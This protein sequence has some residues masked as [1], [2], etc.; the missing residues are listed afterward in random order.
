MLRLILLT[1]IIIVF[2]LNHSTFA[3]EQNMPDFTISKVFTTRGGAHSTTRGTIRLVHDY[4]GKWLVF[5]G[6]PDMYHFSS[7]GV[8]WT[9]QE[10]TQFSSRSYLIR[11]DTIYSFANVDV[12]PDPEKIERVKATFK[13][14]ISGNIIEWGEPHMLPHLTVSYYEDLQQDSTG[15]FTVSGRVPQ[16]DAEGKVTSTTIEWSR[17]L[18]PN[19]ITAWEPQ[20]QVIHH[21]GDMQS[22]E[23]HENIPL[24]DGKSYL[25]GMLSVNKQ[26]RLYGNLFDGE[27]WGAEDTLLA[28]NMSTVR[29]TDKRMSAVWDSRAKVIHMTYVDHDSQLWYRVCKSPYRSENWS[30]PVKLKPFKVF[31]NVMSMD[32]SKTPAHLC[33]V[34]GKTIYEH[35]D[36]RWQSGELYL[37]KYD[38]ESWSESTLISEPGTKY[39][40]YPNMNED[41][42]KGIG[43]V[44]L[45][46]VPEN[47]RAV[48]NTDHDIMFVS[49][50]AP[51]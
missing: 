51:K 23:V 47:Q 34:Y 7:D 3:E 36:P 42:S 9:E 18:R 30:E 44:Y 16:R 1:A 37:T 35:R 25:I 31:T 11:G 49:T 29:G 27:K 12:D 22:S 17:S 45:I 4:K 39:N 41:V 6:G 8:H 46:G 33:L 48:A 20:Q 2:L 40:W 13:G 28:E 14:K 24:E 32:M 43:V 21:I 19:D 26:G 38:G 50:G 5:H 10:I 15:R